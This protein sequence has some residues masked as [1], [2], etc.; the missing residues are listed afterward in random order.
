MAKYFVK[1]S[2]T[3]VPDNI[4]VVDNVFLD[5]WQGVDIEER[6][7]IFKRVNS[8]IVNKEYTISSIVLL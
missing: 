4:E 3:T 5:T 8:N 7:N 1:Y 6:W 2:Y